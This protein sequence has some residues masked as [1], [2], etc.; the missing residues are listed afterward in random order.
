[1]HQKWP[2]SSSSHTNK[3]CVDDQFPS[4]FQLNQNKK[5]VKKSN[6][7]GLKS[8][9][10][11]SNRFL[12]GLFLCQ[13]LEKSRTAWTSFS[14]C[15]CYLLFISSIK[16]RQHFIN[17]QQSGNQVGPCQLSNKIEKKKTGNGNK[18]FVSANDS[19]LFQCFLCQENQLNFFSF[20]ELGKLFEIGSEGENQFKSTEVSP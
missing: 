15:E 18:W 10:V 6:A 16:L 12:S 14:S 17:C 13:T 9:L 1:M 3:Y 4:I 7:N 5:F 20:L 2:S 19:S 8:K 11:I